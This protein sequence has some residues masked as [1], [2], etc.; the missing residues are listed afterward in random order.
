MPYSVVVDCLNSMSARA[1]K[2]LL[3]V[4][5]LG[6]LRTLCPTDDEIKLVKG[7]KGDVSRLGPVRGAAR[8][9]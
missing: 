2:H 5:E 3:S 9:E 1:G 6:N 7:F 4:V 8:L